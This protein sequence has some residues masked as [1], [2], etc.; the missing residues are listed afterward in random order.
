[1]TVNNESLL[2]IASMAQSQKNCNLKVYFWIFFW[3]KE[4]KP[5]LFFKLNISDCGK[6]LENMKPALTHKAA[7]AQALKA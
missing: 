4:N 6:G 2:K 1:M 5:P 7:S 3:I